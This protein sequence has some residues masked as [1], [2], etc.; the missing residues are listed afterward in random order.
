[1]IRTKPGETPKSR[2]T[3]A[4][5]RPPTVQASKIARVRGAGLSFRLLTIPAGFN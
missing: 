5:L 2:A 4:A 1:M 3:S